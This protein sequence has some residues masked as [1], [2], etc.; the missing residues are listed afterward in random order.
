MLRTG[1]SSQSA[2]GVGGEISAAVLIVFS[3]PPPDHTFDKWQGLV[4]KEQEESRGAPRLCSQV[5][6]Q[7]DRLL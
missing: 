5:V 4:I 1:L 7:I 2:V 6:K 3:L